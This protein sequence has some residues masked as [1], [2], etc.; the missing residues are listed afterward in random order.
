MRPVSRPMMLVGALQGLVLWWL[1]RASEDFF[2][3][4]TQPL[5]MGTLLWISVAVPAAYYLSENAD[6]GWKRR[7]RLLALVALA[8]GMLGGYA[9][10]MGAP[11]DEADRMRRLLGSANAFAQVLAAG[12]MGFILLPLVSGWQG[13]GK[14]FDYPVLFRVAWRNALLGASVFAVTGLFW[15]VLFAGAMLMKSIG[16]KFVEE[17]IQKP[18]FVFPV[19]GMVVGGAFAVGHAR[20]ELLI[21]LRRY[22]LALNTWLL[23]LLLAF[24]VLWVAFLPVTGLAPLLATRSAAFTLLWFA[25]LAVLFLNCAWQDGE[26]DPLYSHWLRKLLAPAWLTLLFVTGIAG[27]ALWQRI[28]QY[29]LTEDR[30]WAVFVWLLAAGYALGY[31]LS[32]FPS[33][34]RPSWRARFSGRWM[35]TV[36]AS[37]VVIALLA[38][39]CL[40]LLTSPVLDPRRLGVNAQL[41]RLASGEVAPEDFDYAYLRWETGRWGVLALKALAA[42][43]HD[44]ASRAIAGFARIELAK[45]NRWGDETGKKAQLSRE[46]ARAHLQILAASRTAAAPLPDSL[47]DYL[48]GQTSNVYPSRCLQPSRSCSVWLN[49]LNGDGNPDALV[50]VADRKGKWGE[51]FLLTSAGNGWRQLAT[52]CC[53]LTPE[54]WISHIRRGEVRAVTPVWPDLKVGSA[55]VRVEV[56]DEW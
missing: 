37:N 20:A 1:W 3:P 33:W 54:Q 29:G 15:A 8:Y 6:L 56:R 11:L 18:I 46:E 35:P 47:V 49:D 10:W 31:S 45:K 21:N 55:R 30:V 50:I 13:A 25:A 26:D 28:A 5:A 40:A 2:W 19:T 14:R 4:A 34:W 43:S 12:V 42:D 9:G 32:L 23:P 48:R 44:E 16:I 22:W 41:A 51:T 39:L 24:G 7:G 27:W 17:L 52:L 36:G 53:S 38:L